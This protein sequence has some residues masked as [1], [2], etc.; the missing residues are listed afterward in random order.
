M[1]HLLL[2][3]YSLQF[4]LYTLCLRC[5]MP[6]SSLEV[7]LYAC[8]HLYCRW[9][10]LEIT[11]C[12][13]HVREYLGHFLFRFSLRRSDPITCSPYGN[14]QGTLKVCCLI[15]FACCI[16][17]SAPT[18]WTVGNVHDSCL[19]DDVCE[20]PGVDVYGA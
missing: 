5:C 20:R 14:T 4:T 13:L 10:V 2:H 1:F 16:G 7:H 11:L 3:G 8:V 6:S 18:V 9:T 12:Y 19:H 17:F 15:L